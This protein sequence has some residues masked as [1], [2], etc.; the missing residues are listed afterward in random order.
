M[1]ARADILAYY[2]AQ[3]V[4]ARDRIKL[5]ETG[6]LGMHDIGPPGK[7]VTRDAIEIEKTLIADLERGIAVL[8]RGS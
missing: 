3:I 7:D 6:A 4:L 5:F 8:E 1:S 2:R